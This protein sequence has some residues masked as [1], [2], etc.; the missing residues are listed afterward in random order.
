MKGREGRFSSLHSR[1]APGSHIQTGCPWGIWT[2]CLSL[3]LSPAKQ[4]KAKHKPCVSN[5]NEKIGP[6]CPQTLYRLPWGWH[7]CAHM[8]LSACPPKLHDR[9]QKLEITCVQG[10]RSLERFCKPAGR[11]GSWCLLDGFVLKVNW[12]DLL[13]TSCPPRSIPPTQRL[14]VPSLW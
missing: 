6:L 9:P 8:H 13:S 1:P 5:A 4:S 2:P 12:P 7:N 11:A 3:F 14:C 10:V